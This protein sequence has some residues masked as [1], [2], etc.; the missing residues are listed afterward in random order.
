MG[1][2]ADLREP[3]DLE[4]RFTL[5]AGA[6]PVTQDIRREEAIRGRRIID[7]PFAFDGALRPTRWEAA[8]RLEWRG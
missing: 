5:W 6:G 3:Y 7:V 1:G 2:P 8:V 4:A